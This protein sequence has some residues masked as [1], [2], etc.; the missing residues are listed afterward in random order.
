MLTTFNEIDMS[1]VMEIRSR[2]KDAFSSHQALTPPRVLTS[3]GEVVAG[4]Y[5]RGDLP[6]AAL[7]GLPVS[8]GTVEGR[9]RVILD[10]AEA[11][12]E[13][14]DI[15][16]TAYT[17]PSWTPL[18]VAIAVAFAAMYWWLFIRSTPPA[19]F[20]RN[21][22]AE[23]VPAKPDAAAPAPASESP[24]AMSPAPAIEPPKPPAVSAEPEKTVIAAGSG[25]I[26]KFRFRG[27]SWVEIRDG[28]GKV[29]D[30][31]SLADQP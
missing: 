14:G 28:R 8:A 31:V 2:R 25:G 9:A 6:P 20:A 1:A 13:A 18:F 16:V 24:A 7:A 27:E 30:D 19:T 21:V 10:M 23:P 12:L 22:P 5:R 3:D 17:D 26:L 15:L 4:R 29:I 11:D